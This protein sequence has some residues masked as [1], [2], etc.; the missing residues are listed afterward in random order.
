MSPFSQGQRKIRYINKRDKRLKADLFHGNPVHSCIR[1]ADMGIKNNRSDT[2]FNN[3]NDNSVLK[4]YND[5]K[6]ITMLIKFNNIRLFT[7][8]FNKSKFIMP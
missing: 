8:K 1:N 2:F 7:K 3:K 5:K 6:L 4:F